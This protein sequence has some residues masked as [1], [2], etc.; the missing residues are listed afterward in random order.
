MFQLLW[1][2]LLSLLM[3]IRCLTE[4]SPLVLALNAASRLLA[5]SCG[6]VSAESSGPKLTPREKVPVSVRLFAPDA[7]GSPAPVLSAVSTAS[8]AAPPGPQ[9]TTPG[10]EK[11]LSLATAPLSARTSLSGWTA[12]AGSSV[13]ETV[14]PGP[15][16]SCGLST[17][18]FWSVP[19]WQLLPSSGLISWNFTGCVQVKRLKLV[20]APASWAS[21][22]TWLYTPPRAWAVLQML[23]TVGSVAVAQPSAVV[24]L[25]GIRSGLVD[26]TADSPASGGYAGTG[27]PVELGCQAKPNCTFTGSVTVVVM[28]PIVIEPPVASPAVHAA[29][30]P[31]L[32]VMGITSC[33]IGL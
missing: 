7:E 10:A 18:G 22:K 25:C 9:P 13:K 19:M 26:S 12:G 24:R 15:R 21:A 17:I 30:P 1:N 8:S 29:K 6:W 32:S 23:R 5:A 28:L 33:M 16:D 11:V 20:S 3:V 2:R 31:P 14:P 27:K 4:C